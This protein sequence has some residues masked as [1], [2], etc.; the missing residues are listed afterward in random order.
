MMKNIYT[1]LDL[2]LFGVQ[3]FNIPLEVLN[4]FIRSCKK[5]KQMKKKGT[6]F[7]ILYRRSYKQLSFE[8]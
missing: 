3:Q 1:T 2:R 4:H 8:Q 7:F 6:T 5:N